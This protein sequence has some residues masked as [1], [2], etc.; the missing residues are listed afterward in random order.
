MVSDFRDNLFFGK[1]LQFQLKGD[2]LYAYSLPHWNW[3]FKWVPICKPVENI[4]IDVKKVVVCME[5]NCFFIV[6][7]VQ[8]PNEQWARLELKQQNKQN[9]SIRT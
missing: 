7:I 5:A 2:R 3:I 8:W 6:C 4:V 1:S 9:F